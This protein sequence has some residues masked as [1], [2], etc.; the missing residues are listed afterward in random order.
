MFDASADLGYPFT[1]GDTTGV[2]KTAVVAGLSDDAAGIGGAKLSLVFTQGAFPPGGALAFGIDR[3]TIADHAGGNSAD[4]LAGSKVT[5]RFVL[6]DGVTKVK[7]SG[8]LV[9]RTGHGY[10][11][12][13][14]YGLINAQAALQALLTGQ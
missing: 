5:A 10:S 14:G 9:N 13:V 4:L 1:V 8:T 6:A 12:D 7:L 2:A 11:P 3:D